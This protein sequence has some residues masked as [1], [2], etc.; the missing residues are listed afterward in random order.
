MVLKHFIL[1]LFVY[2][3]KHAEQN[4]GL[5]A[6]IFSSIPTSNFPSLLWR[7]WL[8]GTWLDCTQLSLIFDTTPI[9]T[10]PSSPPSQR[11]LQPWEREINMWGKEE[12]QGEE[13]GS[14]N[15]Q[16]TVGRSQKP[17]LG[18]DLVE[19]SWTL[20]EWLT[21]FHEGYLGK[22]FH[23]LKGTVQISACV[24]RHSIAWTIH[25][26]KILVLIVFAP[27]CSSV[28][29]CHHIKT[30]TSGL[31]GQEG[32][33]RTCGV[34]NIKLF[35]SHT[36]DFKKG[37]G[38]GLLGICQHCCKPRMGT[39]KGYSQELWQRN[40]ILRVEVR[41]GSEE[42][43]EIPCGLGTLYTWPGG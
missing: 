24:W 36:V 21:Q 26:S 32:L 5:P 18:V 14:E 17:E 40:P 30:E 23:N 8:I 38:F 35:C 37:L 4:S 16:M 15:L 2:S 29:F 13:K 28:L 10:H 31:D 7:P 1:L 9:H 11:A 42:Y 34:G 3:N 20:Q 39:L 43:S 33:L 19:E 6:A 12:G 41:H 27:F 25:P 22:G